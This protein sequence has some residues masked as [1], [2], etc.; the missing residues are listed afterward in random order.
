MTRACAAAELREDRR[1]DVGRRDGG[2]T[3]GTVRQAVPVEDHQHHDLADAER[4]NRDVMPA[5][6]KRRKND[7]RAEERGDHARGRDRHR[8]GQFEV[9]RKQS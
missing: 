5:Q 2:E 9:D 1:R 6:A 7:E 4:R 8:H 3:D